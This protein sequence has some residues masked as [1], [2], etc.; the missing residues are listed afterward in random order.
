MP[1]TDEQRRR[2]EENNRQAILRRN[3]SGK[4]APTA[5]NVTSC[6]NKTT[7]Y[8]T[9]EIKTQLYSK[10]PSVARQGLAGVAISNRAR[11]SGKCVLTTQDRFVVV[12]NYQAE[13]IDIFKQ[14]RTGK[15]NAKDRNWTFKVE[16]H[17]DLLRKLRPLQASHNVHIEALPKWI[18]DTVFQYGSRIIPIEDI[19]V[20][21]IESSIFDVL[22]PFQVRDLRNKNLGIHQVYLYLLSCL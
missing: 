22:M 2:M 3:A 21:R 4:A 19:D 6:S 5:T 9:K 17:D 11:I 1:L 8:G 16:E 14:S 20:S 10:P 7:F 13:V 12:V 15:Y 18:L